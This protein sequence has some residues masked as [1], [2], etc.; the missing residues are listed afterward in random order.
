MHVTPLL[1]LRPSHEIESDPKQ[2]NK[3]M[4]AGDQLTAVKIQTCWTEYF[5]CCFCLCCDPKI[6]ERAA[7]NIFEASLLETHGPFARM[8]LD[9]L[10]IHFGKMIRAGEFLTEYRADEIRG[11]VVVLKNFLLGEDVQNVIKRLGFFLLA[12]NLK[13]DPQEDLEV[14]DVN[15]H[16]LQTLKS[17]FTLMPLE[18]PLSEEEVLAFASPIYLKLRR[19]NIKDLMSRKGVRIICEEFQRKGVTINFPSELCQFDPERAY[20]IIRAT[21][22]YHNQADNF[23]MLYQRYLLNKYGYV[24]EKILLD[25]E[26][27]QLTSGGDPFRAT[28]WNDIR[29]LDLNDAKDLEEAACKALQRPFHSLATTARSLTSPSFGLHSITPQSGANLDDFKAAASPTLPNPTVLR[30]LPAAFESRGNPTAPTIKKISGILPPKLS[31]PGLVLDSVD[32]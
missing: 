7:I 24:S 8:A 26:I 28:D 25:V 20:Y 10:Q 30:A 4:G 23:G 15:S 14:I 12:L 19:E 13:T 21:I 17:L 5:S 11:Q 1:R 29:E 27:T 31:I 3:L 16:D 6:G 32:G 9:S 18:K 2:Q 22:E